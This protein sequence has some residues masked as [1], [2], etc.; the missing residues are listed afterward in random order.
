DSLVRTD[1]H[2]L[3]NPLLNLVIKARHDVAVAGLIRV[4]SRM[5]RLVTQKDAL[6]PAD[7]DRL[8][9]ED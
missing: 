3:E 7:Y 2:Q 9:V 6:L 5:L 4:R 1:H 8:S